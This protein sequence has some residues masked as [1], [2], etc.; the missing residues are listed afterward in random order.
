MSFSSKNVLSVVVSVI[1]W[2]WLSAIKKWI[3]SITHM[4]LT[5]AVTSEKLNSYNTSLTIGKL[6]YVRSTHG[7]TLCRTV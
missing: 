1:K 5:A 6:G 2:W 7:H 4:N 3:M